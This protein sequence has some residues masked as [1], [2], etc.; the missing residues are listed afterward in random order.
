VVVLALYYPGIKDAAQ[1]YADRLD[2]KVV[3]DITNPV[4]TQTWD[5][6][7]TEP[8]SSSAAEVAQ[9]VPRGAPV[10]KAFNTTFAN[11]LVDRK[12][13]GEQPD[14]LSRG[15]TTRRRRRSRN[16]S[17]TAA[18]ARSMWAR[19]TERSSSSSWD[20]STSRFRSRTASTSG[21]RSSCIRERGA[22]ALTSP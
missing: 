16:S 8:G 9:L 7:A 18:S 17:P 20:S 19:S 22:A 10:V 5:R 21:A 4:D 12:V 1:Q 13:D 2:G 14:V 15:T 3:V 11:T 6:L